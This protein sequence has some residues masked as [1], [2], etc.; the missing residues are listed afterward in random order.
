MKTVPGWI[1]KV[2]SSLL[3]LALIG[4]TLNIVLNQTVLSTTYL[5]GQLKKADAYHKLSV[6]IT[7]ELVHN[8]TSM[9]PE[10]SAKVQSIVTPEVLEQ[11]IPGALQQLEDYMK[12]GGSAPQVDVSDLVAQARAAGVD[13]PANSSLD[14]P[15]TIGQAGSYKIQPPSKTAKLVNTL[16]VVAAVML[17]ATLVLVCWLRRDFRPLARLA[18]WYGVVLGLIALVLWFAPDILASRIHFA[19][20]NIFAS[21]SQEIATAIAKDIAKRFVTIAALALA[22]GIPAWILLAKLQ[23]R[24]TPTVVKPSGRSDV[25]NPRLGNQQQ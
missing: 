7:D 10:L 8:T 16:M 14:K 5:D 15:I 3:L 22:V 13:I 24:A 25:T 4:L 20:V 6:A 17:G 2:I 12:N 18:T 11:R 21:V 23:K 19:A 1:T 9:D